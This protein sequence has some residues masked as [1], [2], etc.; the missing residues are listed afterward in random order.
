LGRTRSASS[1]TGPDIGEPTRKVSIAS[2]GPEPGPSGGIEKHASSVSIPTTAST[3][4]AS[5]AFM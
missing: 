2:R 3:S 5:H 1:A 4:Q